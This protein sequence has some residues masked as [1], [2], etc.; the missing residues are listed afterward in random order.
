MDKDVGPREQAVQDV[1]R[2]VL[3]QVQSQGLLGA[4][5]PDEVARE[6][7][8][9]GVV[10]AGEVAR[11]LGRSIFITLAPRSASWRVAKGAAT[12]CSSAT[13]V[14]PSS[15]SIS[16]G[17]RKS[18]DVFCYVGEDEVRRDRGDLEEPRLAELAL[19]VVLGVV[20]V[21]TEGLHRHVRGL[22]GCLRG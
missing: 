22:P 6:T 15:G 5:E 3:F 8:H 11:P 7:L 2:A 13:T 16:E 4:V 21:A 17:P 20:A 1:L 12:A 9:R 10:A 18:K 19:D 14:M